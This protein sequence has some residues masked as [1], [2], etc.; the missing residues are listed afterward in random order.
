MIASAGTAFVAATEENVTRMSREI[1]SLQ[2]RLHAAEQ[3]EKIAEQEK[4]ELQAEVQQLRNQALPVN[5]V[6]LA[7]FKECE[8]L[9]VTM[10][11]VYGE[12]FTIKQTVAPLARA[13]AE[14][15]QRHE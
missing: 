8:V 5:E 6:S 14:T 13:R 4:A 11:Q 2:N 15:R 10:R 9:E 3:R 1:V 7:I 12:M